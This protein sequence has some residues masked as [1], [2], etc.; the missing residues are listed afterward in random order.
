MISTPDG[1]PVALGTVA[2]VEATNGP[3]T[4]NRENVMRRIVVQANVAGRDLASVVDR[5]SR[6]LSTNS[7]LPQG[8]FVEYGGQFE[9]QQ[10]ANLRLLDPGHACRSSGSSCCLCKGL[11]PGGRPCKSWSTF[12]WPPSGRWSPCC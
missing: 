2:K 5:D 4:I 12:P 6:R 11:G 3:N 8:Y 9:A 7:S 1:S 10:E